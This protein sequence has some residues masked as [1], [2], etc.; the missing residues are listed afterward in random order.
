MKGFVE[1]DRSVVE[2]ALF[3]FKKKR[4]EGSEVLDSAIKE[5]YS[6]YYIQGSSFHRW[7]N[8]KH[9]PDSYALNQIPLFGYYSEVMYDVMSGTER[10]LLQ[11]WELGTG[12]A[13]ANACSALLKASSIPTL[14]LDQDL[15]KF[16][17][18]Y[19]EEK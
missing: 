9:T 10:R 18:E 1:V 2:Q 8:R 11:W 19:K 6:K 14:L 3:N 16:V 12:R 7:W 15:C 4:E 5:F 13:E 17:N